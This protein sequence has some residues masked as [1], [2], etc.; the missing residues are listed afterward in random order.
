MPASLVRLGLFPAGDVVD[1][2]FFDDQ[3]VRFSERGSITQ[4][5][6]PGDYEPGSPGQR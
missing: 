4:Q 5:K 3:K 2:P 6:N 1:V